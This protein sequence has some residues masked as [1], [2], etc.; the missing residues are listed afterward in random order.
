MATIVNN[1]GR[2]IAEW[3]IYH[4]L[5]GFDH[6]YIYDDKSSD[7]TRDVVRA[8]EQIGW[9]TL[10]D[11][12]EALRRAAGIEIPPHVRFQ[13]QF[14]IVQH[15]ART[16]A[17]EVEWLGFFDVDE[18]LFARRG[19][20]CVSDLVARMHRGQGLLRMQGLLFLPN[21]TDAAPLPAATTLVSTAE[22]F[23]P[24]RRIEGRDRVPLHKNFARPSAIA[25]FDHSGIH[26]MMVKPAYGT[27][28]IK[29]TDASFAH[30]RYRTMHDFALKQKK[31]YAGHTNKHDVWKHLRK[32][33]AK[34]VSQAATISV[35]HPLRRYA[36]AVDTAYAA[37]RRWY[38][39]PEP[40]PPL[41][42]TVT[43]A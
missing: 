23:V 26:H 1:E 39:L 5:V 18:F 8:F 37:F 4:R 15:A 11:D 20:W 43:F 38:A 40:R 34:Y 3:M 2:W 7:D 13:P 14:V 22:A 30:F 42:L 33:L 12:V 36:P 9:A 35:S 27:Q 25:D 32:M 17:R 31:A 29:M 24:F 19:L 21:V 16:Y 10:H 28:V 6:F 41:R